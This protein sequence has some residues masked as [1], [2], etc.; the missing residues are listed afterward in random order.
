MTLGEFISKYRS[1]HN[2]SI[3]AFGRLT[4]LSP[5]YINNIEKGTNNDGNSLSPTIS[6]YQRIADGLGIPLLELLAAI[7]DSVTINSEYTLEEQWVV[8]MYR[9]ADEDDRTIVK[10]ALR[11][12]DEPYMEKEA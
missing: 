6:T 1:E 3:R 8:N 9:R 12:Y 7:N 11:K 4:S 10:A 5:T 2:M